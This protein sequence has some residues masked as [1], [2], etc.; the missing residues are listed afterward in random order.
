MSSRLL[1]Q[2]VWQGHFWEIT[3]AFRYAQ[4]EGC[5]KS[6]SD[7]KRASHRNVMQEVSKR[8][9]HE[10]S[11]EELKTESDMCAMAGWLIGSLVGCLVGGCVLFG[12]WFGTLPGCVC[13]CRCVCVWLPVCV[14]VNMFSRAWVFVWG[15]LSCLL[16]G[17]VVYTCVC[18]SL[19][20]SVYVCVYVCVSFLFC[21]CLFVY[22]FVSLY[23]CVLFFVSVIVLMLTVCDAAQVQV[24]PSSHYGCNWHTIKKWPS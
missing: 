12:W 10:A 14:C 15:S 24:W 3:E 9:R 19:R 4:Q 20:V 16:C 21:L 11:A 2:E 22:L 6:Q 17:C 13:V 18:M 23:V 7:C 5:V 1:W 8:N